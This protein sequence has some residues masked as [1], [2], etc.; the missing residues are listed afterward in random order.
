MERRKEEGIYFRVLGLKKDFR[1]T[2]S[3][4]P[5]PYAYAQSFL[6]VQR[7]MAPPPPSPPLLGQR[8][9]MGLYVTLR[10]SPMAPSTVS[11]DL[12]QKRPTTERERERESQRTLLTIKERR[13]LLTI[14]VQSTSEKDN[15]SHEHTEFVTHMKRL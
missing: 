1:A 14:A 11:E 6:N 10:H 5:S 7:H 2:V 15:V 13:G 3:R 9:P 12:L 4:K 8:V